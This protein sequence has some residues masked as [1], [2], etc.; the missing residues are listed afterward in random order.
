MDGDDNNLISMKS[1]YEDRLSSLQSELL[2]TNEEL[3]KAR[4]SIIPL[5]SL[6][7]NPPYGTSSG[8][9]ECFGY[10]LLGCSVTSVFFVIYL[11]TLLLTPL[12]GLHFC[13][14]LD[15]VTPSCCNL[16]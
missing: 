5:S 14:G 9:G 1:E 6:P 13:V 16:F 4:L 3:L 7:P 10:L 11:L 12:A 15:F 8:I 2:R